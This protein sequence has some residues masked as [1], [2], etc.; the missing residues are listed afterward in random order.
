[1]RESVGDDC[2][3]N[4]AQIRQSRPD[5]GLSFQEQVLKTLKLLPRRSG[6]WGAVC[7]RRCVEEEMFSI[8]GVGILKARRGR[9]VG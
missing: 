5:S 4:V 2:Q 8:L 3:A 7:R 1:M 6:A 9:G